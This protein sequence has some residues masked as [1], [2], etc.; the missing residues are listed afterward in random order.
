MQKEFTGESDEERIE[1][2]AMTLMRAM[3]EAL[4]GETVQ[5]RIEGQFEGKPKTIVVRMHS[6]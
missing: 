3:A 6:E 2:V 5:I 1:T 4:T